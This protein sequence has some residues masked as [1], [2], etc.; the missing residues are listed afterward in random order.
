MIS[1]YP[2]LSLADTAILLITAGVL[3][4]FVECV[5]PGGVLPGAG[6]L[7]LFLLGV[8]DLASLPLRPAALLLLASAVALLAAGAHRRLRWAGGLLG[9]A[10][11]MAALPSLVRPRQWLPL[12]NVTPWLG[13]AAGLLL[14]GSSSLLLRIAA[15]ARANKRE[16]I[17]RKVT[18]G[19]GERRPRE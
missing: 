10:A 9:T 5:R 1:L 7:L 4:A 15:Q 6:G 16:P 18:A 3:L 14:G 12:Q 19:P 13:A 2:G 8:H 17:R 11:L